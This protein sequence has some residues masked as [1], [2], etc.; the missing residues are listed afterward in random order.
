M[1]PAPDARKK[2]FLIDGSGYIFRAFYAIRGLANTKGF[3]TNAVFGFTN[4]LL[5]AIRDHVPDYVV[6]AFDT[7]GKTFRDDLFADYKAQRPEMPEDLAPQIPYIHKIVEGFRLGRMEREGYEA[8]D[9]IGTLVEHLRGEDIDTV[10]VSGDKDLLQLVGDGVT[11]LDTMKDVTYGREEVIGRFGVPPEKVVEVLGLAGDST[12]NIPGVPGI[13]EK[14]AS[15]LIRQFGSIE[16]LL[17][18][19]EEVKGEK[20]RENLRTYR[21]QALLSRR[22]ATIDRDV[23]LEFRL[24][25][26]ALREPD[27][28]ALTAVF[29]ELEFERLLR[30][31]G[32]ERKTITYEGYRTLLSEEELRDFLGKAV[33]SGEL[34]VDLETTSVD[35]MRAEIVGVALAGRPGEAAYVPLAHT[36]LGLPAQ[37]SREACLAILKPV[38]EDE[39]TAKVGQNLKYEWIVFRRRGIRLAGI[40]ADAM[41]ASYLLDPSRMR[42]N[43]DELAR[44]HLGHRTITYEDVTGAGKKQIAFAEAP[45]ERASVYACEDAD[46]ALR[47]V[48]KLEPQLEADGLEDLFRRIEMPLLVV[49]ARMEMNGVLV[50]ADLLRRLSDKFNEEL[51]EIET[52]V[53]ELA[54]TRLNLNSPKQLAV[55]LHERLGLPVLKRT[56]KGGIS[57][58][59]DVLERLAVEHALPRE[60][61]RYRQ[62]AKLK[63]TYVDTLPGLI[64]PETG[65]IHTSYNQT[66]T[67]T[68]RL[69]SSD[70]NLQ[71][72]P[73]RTPEGREI[74]RAFIPAPGYRLLSADYSQIE[75]RILAHLSGDPTLMQAFLR[76]EDIHRRT[77]SEVY[78]VPPE[79]VTEEERS[80]AK[81]VN[82]GLM[83]GQGA[84]GLSQQL[85][86]STREAE[87]YI[88][89]YFRHFASVRA[90]FERTLEEARRSGYVTTLLNRRRY[91]TEILSENRHARS[92]AE[93]MAVNTT[94]QGSAADLI[95]AAMFAV[96][97]RL[98]RKS[99]GTLMIMQVHDELVFEVPVGDLERVRRLVTEEMERVL[100]LRVPLRADV[101]DGANWSEAH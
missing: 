23:P 19:V 66:V 28:E 49:L 8:D 99:P 75:L 82:F 20:R 72:I 60:I 93:R 84:F 70:P 1:P 76:G 62:L 86:I 92:A 51:R 52:R 44:E 77:A 39:G 47:L 83:Y 73:I 59:T 5:K 15:A 22:L 29:R 85:G 14:T 90:Y 9:L 31:F 53:Y 91:L 40:R 81:A 58:D 89:G 37:L 68:G 38:L 46:V 101:G 11:M 87:E 35:A 69:S 57:T 67:A 64:H 25:D 50:D 94:I 27:R 74:R 12:D 32:E 88:E 2:I 10:I 95:K 18:R 55:V 36:G 63:G 80:R 17:S 98:D 7:K 3:P 26:F 41:I 24:E 48:H 97:D 6:V 65:R 96:Q 54:G 30:E 45:I 79:Q 43:L 42:H 13:G 34:S 33:T 4:M 100:P 61:V 78:G 56:R 71:N 21:E 16:S